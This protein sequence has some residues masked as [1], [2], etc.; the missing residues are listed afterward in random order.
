M[1]RAAAAAM[2]AVR[3]VLV[4]HLVLA[5]APRVVPLL[6]VVAAIIIVIIVVIVRIIVIVMRL[7]IVIAAVV[8]I[9][10][11]AATASCR[12]TVVIAVHCEKVLE[13]VAR[14]RI[15]L[16]KGGRVA[17]VIVVAVQMAELAPFAVYAKVPKVLGP[18]MPSCSSSSACTP[19]VVIHV[20]VIVDHS[21]LTAGIR[22]E[23]RRRRVVEASPVVWERAVDG[24]MAKPSRV[25]TPT[26][27][28]TT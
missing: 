2:V 4:V 11:S 9:S 27:S 21:A 23:L 3:L 7:V 26:S 12:P 5:L 15:D 8:I 22:V 10:S 13:I 20:G 18:V 16:A 28:S 25:I 14:R 1:A 6:A 17:A 19:A 24:V